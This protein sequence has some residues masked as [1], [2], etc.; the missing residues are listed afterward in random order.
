MDL[1]AAR[2]DLVM[3]RTLE[4][5]RRDLVGMELDSHSH[6]GLEEV[7]RDSLPL[8]DLRDL[9][10]SMLVAGSLVEGRRALSVIVMLVQTICRSFWESTYVGHRANEVKSKGIG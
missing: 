4:V 8:A 10:R 5:V 2:R 1:A 3:V 7:I 9:V 6:T